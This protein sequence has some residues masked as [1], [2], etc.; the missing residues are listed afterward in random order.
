MSGGFATSPAAIRGLLMAA[1]GPRRASGRPARAAVPDRPQ[2]SGQSTCAPGSQGGCASNSCSPSSRV[3]ASSSCGNAGGPGRSARTRA[4]RP[5]LPPQ[6]RPSTG[7]GARQTA[8]VRFLDSFGL[9]CGWGG[10][11]RGALS[12]ATPRGLTEPPLWPICVAL[13]MPVGS[14]NVTYCRITSYQIRSYGTGTANCSV[15][16]H[17][18]RSPRP[19]CRREGADVQFHDSVEQFITVVENPDRRGSRIVKNSD[20]TQSESARRKKSQPA[21]RGLALV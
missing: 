15:S 18:H 7:E 21:I 13:R 11:M 2:E 12:P 19:A 10:R 8:H 16:V 20:G 9:F 17:A 14:R 6:K 3:P 1:P 5:A 4:V